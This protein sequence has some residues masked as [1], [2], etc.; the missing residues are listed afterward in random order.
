MASGRQCF[1]NEVLYDLIRN[2][3]VVVYMDDF[4]VATKIL[5]N[6]LEVLN[7]FQITNRK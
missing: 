3:D 2:D 6:H 5:E 7:R 1:F 4:L